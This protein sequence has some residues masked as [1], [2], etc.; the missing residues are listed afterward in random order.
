MATRRVSIY[1]FLTE[2]EIE[3]AV[4]IYR[5]DRDNFHRRVLMEIINPNMERIDKALGQEN[6]ADYLAYCIEA[7]V[8]LRHA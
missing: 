1:E 5:N 8:G 3:Q 2:A 6:D 4:N 7:V